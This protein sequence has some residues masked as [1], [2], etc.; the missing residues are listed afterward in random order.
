[1]DKKGESVSIAAKVL[2]T[3]IVLFILFIIIRKLAKY[4]I[5]PIT[6]PG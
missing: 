3:I 6:G 5:L 4:M 2:I 1:M